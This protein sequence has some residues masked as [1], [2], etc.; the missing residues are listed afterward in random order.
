MLGHWAAL[1]PLSLPACP[2]PIDAISLGTWA[3][4]F[5][6]R[7]ALLEG[8]VVAEVSGCARLLGGMALLH[9]RVHAGA[10]ELGA[11]VAW[12]PT[13]TAAMCTRPRASDVSAASAVLLRIKENSRHT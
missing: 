6:P 4:Q 13:A 11:R 1:L 5:T 3:L 2:S 8:S 9:Q 12:A 10:D 7:V